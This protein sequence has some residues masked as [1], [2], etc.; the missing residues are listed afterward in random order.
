MILRRVKK[1]ITTARNVN[2]RANGAN[3]EK[4]EKLPNRN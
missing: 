4:K 2:M 3:I 1:R